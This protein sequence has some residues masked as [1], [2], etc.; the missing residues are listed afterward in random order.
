MLE[1]FNK[2]IDSSHDCM[3]FRAI[4]RRTAFAYSCHIHD[5]CTSFT[6]LSE[7]NEVA[8]R[9]DISALPHAL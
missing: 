3:K 7:F 1:C 4:A 2:L 6:H 5:K 9:S 8:E